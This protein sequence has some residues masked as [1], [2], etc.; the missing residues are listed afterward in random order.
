[1]DPL[2]ILPALMLVWSIGFAAQVAMA[3]RRHGVN[4]AAWAVKVALVLAG[5]GAA[6]AFGSEPGVYAAAAAWA[7]FLA[8]PSFAANAHARALGGQDYD[9]ARR[10]AQ[11]VRLLHPFD[12]WRREPDLLAALA[13]LRA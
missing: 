2:V 9:R 1:M 3:W 12:G 7:L 4:V 6:V 5:A 13:R 8:A 10:M 11:V